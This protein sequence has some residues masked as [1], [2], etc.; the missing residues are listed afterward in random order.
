MPLKSML[1]QHKGT[2]SFIFM[3]WIETYIIQIQH[4]F[5]W[6]LPNNLWSFFRSST[7]MYYGMAK[8]SQ[9]VIL[10]LFDYFCNFLSL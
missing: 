10:L 4:L 6:L 2:F 1:L 3:S 7:N 8:P 5:L 9:C